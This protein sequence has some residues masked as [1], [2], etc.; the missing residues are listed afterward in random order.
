LSL[1]AV[2]KMTLAV[3]I[4]VIVVVASAA[5]YMILQG[6][7]PSQVTTTSSAATSE[8]YPLE[9][10]IDQPQSFDTLD[11]VIAASPSGEDIGMICILNLITLMPHESASF[12]PLLAKSWEVSPDQK[13][14]TFHLRENVYYSN[15]DPFNAYA[16]W[17]TIYRDLY[18]STGDQYP[19][20]LVFNKTGVR[21]EDV[22]ALNNSQNMPN[23]DLL[24]LMM[25]P[26]NSVTVV[27][28]NTVEFHL[29]PA[30]PAFLSMLTGV[31]W[32][33]DDP[34]F[35]EQHG[36]VIAGQANSYMTI[37][38]S[39]VGNGPYIVDR[40]V[41]DQYVVLVA[42]PHYWAQNIAEDDPGYFALRPARI[43]KITVN[44][45]PDELT[46]ELDL[47]KNL[48]QAAVIAWP[49]I[50]RLLRETPGL[51]VPEFGLTNHIDWI[52]LNSQ[53]PPLDNILVRKAIIEAINAKQIQEL[54]YG[55]Y[56]KSFVGPLPS[57]LPFYDDSIKP[58]P[59][60]PD[61]AK[62]LLAQAG[63]PDGKGL[64]QL[65]YAYAQA[66]HSTITAQLVQSDLAKIGINVQPVGL[67]ISGLQT[68]EFGTRENVWNTTTAPNMI[69]TWWEWW[70]DFNG[71]AYLV[72]DEL[73]FLQWLHND[74]INYRV[75]KALYE[76][77]P[78]Q[79]A[80]EISKV[81]ELTQQQWV[82][83]WIAQYEN[84]Y[85]TGEPVG[86]VV[87]N[88]CAVGDIWMSYS[89]F[90]VPYNSVYYT[91]APGQVLSPADMAH[92][93]FIASVQ[94]APWSYFAA[95]KDPWIL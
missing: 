41:P 72:S 24:K 2:S 51:V 7:Q 9:F 16:V 53:K 49:D 43:P 34:Y 6:G 3:A 68:I 91:C 30:M 12:A 23:A 50:P 46:R 85:N 20:S 18:E 28:A 57:G 1:H 75:N 25:N 69:D 4:V 36:G 83:I 64:P 56:A 14:Y 84:F 61:D 63:Y 47:Q 39:D 89:W 58:P 92:S 42:N 77:D 90:G 17:W 70:P 60:D 19:M 33:F 78:Q 94:V 48:A 65:T 87:W 40:A 67:T 37:H 11:P 74:T 81:T 55:G 8:Q 82:F 62:R 93:S 73:G 21:L 88:K 5:S 44:F 45:K 80:L 76:L 22:N 59:Y 29:Y 95:R 79:R 54:A 66:P 86:Q 32:E 13:T 31:A 38:G 15:G 52:T 35:Y 71:Y 26:D 27:D 10:T